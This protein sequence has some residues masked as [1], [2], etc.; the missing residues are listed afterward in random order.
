MLWG[1]HGA[2]RVM[3]L[4]PCR[5]GVRRY[6]SEVNACVVLVNWPD[7]INTPPLLLDLLCFCKMDARF[8]GEALMCFF[9]RPLASFPVL[10]TLV[11]K[12]WPLYLLPVTVFFAF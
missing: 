3:C 8:R 1:S 10:N 5:Q 7:E 9:L 6:A 4:G 2:G 11:L 12:A